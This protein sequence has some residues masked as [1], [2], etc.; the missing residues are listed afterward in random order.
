MILGS[1][2]VVRNGTS[3]DGNAPRIVYRLLRYS[4][5]TGTQHWI[6]RRST[7]ILTRPIRSACYHWASL[8]IPVAWLRPF[9]CCPC[10][11]RRDRLLNLHTWSF[12]N[13]SSVIYPRL[14]RRHTAVG[15]HRCCEIGGDKRTQRQNKSI[16]YQLLQFEIQDI[17]V[18]TMFH[19]FQN[20]R[21]Q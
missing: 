8:S 17:A 16:T 4:L 20:P 21:R 18:E 13:H 3:T 6:S 12:S 1:V 7:N 9:S 10:R 11:I 2:H 14:G 15:R 5:R 19:E